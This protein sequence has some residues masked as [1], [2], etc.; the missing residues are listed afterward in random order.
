MVGVWVIDSAVVVVAAGG[1]MGSAFSSW[2]TGDGDRLSEGVVR[3]VMVDNELEDCGDM[4]ESV[5]E[6][7]QNI[8]VDRDG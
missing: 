2:S 4:V 1:V 7:V 5:K 3:F 8:P 6:I